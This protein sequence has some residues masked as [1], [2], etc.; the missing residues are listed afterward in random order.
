MPDCARCGS[1]LEETAEHAFYF[2]KRVHPFWDHVGE[3]T[4]RIEPKLLVLLDVGY[5]M[6]NVLPPFQGDKRGIY[7]DP[8]C[9][10]NGDWD[11]AKE[12]IV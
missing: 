11:D 9:N 3:W 10:L 6:D 4:T 2:C 8:R 1:G 12:G 7:C 5:V